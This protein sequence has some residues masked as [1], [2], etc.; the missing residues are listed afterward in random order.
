MLAYQTYQVGARFEA[1]D[2]GFLMAPLDTRY[3][4]IEFHSI[5]VQMCV[6]PVLLWPHLPENE[7]R[8]KLLFCN[9][10]GEGY[11]AHSNVSVLL[12]VYSG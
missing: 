11:I 7:P 2:E 4:Q 1:L 8:L 5:S 9:L 12:S 10:S 3:T 6:S